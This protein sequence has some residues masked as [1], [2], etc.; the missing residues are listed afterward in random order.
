MSTATPVIPTDHR[1]VHEHLD[2]VL[3]LAG[4]GPVERV[5]LAAA[6]GRV[7][8][9]DVVTPGDLP[10]FTSSA[11]DGYA[12]R[13][14]DPPREG[15]TMPRG[16]GELPV[17]A[18]VPAGCGTP[19]PLRR[20]STARIMT[21][22]PVPVG[23]DTVV[24]VEWTTPGDVGT[25]LVH[26]YPPRG[27]YVRRAA[28]EHRAGDI[29][30]R[31]GCRLTP[32]R[33]ALLA[34]SGATTAHVCRRPRVL[35]LTTGNE[36]VTPGTPR[37]SGGVYD[38]NTTLL[39]GLLA[40]DGAH[41]TLL[42]HRDDEHRVLAAL[43]EGIE[44]HDLLLTAGGISPG[45]HEPVRQ[46]LT[47]LG[48]VQFVDVAMSPG[49][50]QGCGTLGDTPVL[51]LPGNPVAALVS[52]LAFARPFLRHWQSE[53]DPTGGWEPVTVRGELRHRPGTVLY[54]PAALN[55]TSGHPVATV[56]GGGHRLCEL[57]AADGVLRIDAGAAGAVGAAVRSAELHV[58]R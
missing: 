54:R 50:P 12:V 20:G 38:A 1:P 30:L 33:L 21:G 46:A 48:G 6:L 47:S 57:A 41:V 22:A 18:T 55:R 8:A 45:D 51:A 24:P 52:Y 31:T 13:L 40:E 10:P 19:V 39:A 4:R 17:R 29:L 53:P 14:A 36:L 37:P 15:G 11:I 2:A 7:L 3:T 56:V 16:G 35:L 26:R 49:G 34:S 32:A 25:I 27:T 5:P 58:F 42:R 43:L 23:A 28:Q 9:A 44:D